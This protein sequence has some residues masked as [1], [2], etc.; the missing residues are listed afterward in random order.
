MSDYKW[1]PHFLDDLSKARASGA[2]WRQI[3]AEI[4]RAEREW[5]DRSGMYVLP[6][7]WSARDTEFIEENHE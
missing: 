7:E 5:R 6:K 1:L 3:H 2:T 4:W